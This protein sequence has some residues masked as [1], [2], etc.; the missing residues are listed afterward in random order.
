VCSIIPTDILE[1]IIASDDAHPDSKAAAERTLITTQSLRDNR[2]AFVASLG[3][4]TAESVLAKKLPESPQI[5]TIMRLVYTASNKTILPGTLQRAEGQPATRDTSI[6][7]CYDGLGYMYDFMDTIFHRKSIDDSNMDI[8]GTV[9]YDIGF[10]NAF[11]N[12][13]QMVFGDAMALFSRASLL[14]W[15]L[16]VT[17]LLTALPNILQTWPSRVKAG[18]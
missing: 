10:G 9:H 11:W 5:T 4:P 14:F 3:A 13:E 12:G 6:N 8:I 18:P 17:S 1:A 2:D 16:S 7:E 15:M